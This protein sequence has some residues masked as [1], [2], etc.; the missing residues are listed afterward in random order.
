MTGQNIGFVTEEV[1]SFPFCNI[2][3]GEIVSIEI[4]LELFCFSYTYKATLF[5]NYSLL[6]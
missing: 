1:Y 5:G 3:L 2:D 4:L 6:K